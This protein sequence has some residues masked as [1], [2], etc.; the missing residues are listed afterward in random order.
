M[1]GNRLPRPQDLPVRIV[2]VVRGEN[3]GLYLKD[4]ETGEEFDLGEGQILYAPQY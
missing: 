4:V 2:C 3:G 1:N